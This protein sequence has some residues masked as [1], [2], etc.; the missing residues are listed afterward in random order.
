MNKEQ[1]LD[2][3]QETAEGYFERGEFFCSEA[4][5]QTINDALG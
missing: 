3:I 4:V 1:Y 5:L 2:Q